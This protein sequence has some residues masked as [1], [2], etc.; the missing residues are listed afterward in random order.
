MPRAAFTDTI[1]SVAADGTLKAIGN[2]KVEVRKASDDTLVN[3]YSQREGGA[4]IGTSITTGA[5]GLVEF[6]AEAGEYNITYTDLTAPA[7]ITSP[8]TFGW[9]SVP[10]SQNPEA[11]G[12]TVGDLKLSSQ[13]VD[14]GRWLRLDGRELTQ[15]EVEASLG[16]TAGD[17]AEIMSYLGTGSGSKYGAAASSKIKLADTRRRYL[18]GTGPT[19]DGSGSLSVRALGA[20]GGA[21]TITLTKTQSGVPVHSHGITDNGHFHTADGTLQAALAGVAH[22]HFINDMK[23]I[24]MNNGGGGNGQSY[25]FMFDSSTDNQVNT[26]NSGFQT[27]HS[28]DVTGNTSSSSTGLTV[29]NHAGADAAVA[30][31]N[32]SPFVSIGYVFIRV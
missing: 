11:L 27:L 15:L 10:G 32:M 21:E 28:H 18:M 17:G 13:S 3:L 12:F 8:R 30:H 9:D 19:D 26:D 16:L 24:L 4:S 5:S 1:A 7:R 22:T 31:D 14:H 2:V 25:Y 20:T 29:N 23:A 6:Y